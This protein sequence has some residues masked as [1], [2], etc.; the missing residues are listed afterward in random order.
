M[1]ALYFVKQHISFLRYDLY[2]LD[3]YTTTYNIP[4]VPKKG[5]YVFIGMP[6]FWQYAEILELGG[7]VTVMFSALG[8]KI[9][10]IDW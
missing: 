5:C 3:P 7:Q 10:G 9:A 1:Y 6:Y 2:L 8:Y 4:D